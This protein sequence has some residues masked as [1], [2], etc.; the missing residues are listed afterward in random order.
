M[1]KDLINIANTLDKRGLTKEADI[2]DILIKKVAS[3]EYEIYEDKLKIF[4]NPGLNKMD[5]IRAYEQAHEEFFGSNDG[6]VVLDAEWNSSP[7]THAHYIITYTD[8]NI[9]E[10]VSYNQFA[11]DEY[12][13]SGY[14]IEIEDKDGKV[15]YLYAE[16]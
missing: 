15:Y 9:S 3:K 4:E 14:D 16:F 10:K 6:L 12:R 11:L 8:Q 1:I 2:L 5:V 13:N 7:T